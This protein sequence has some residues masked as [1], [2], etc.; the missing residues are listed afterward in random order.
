MNR[1]SS[2]GNRAVCFPGSSLSSSVDYVV[3][4]TGTYSVSIVETKSNFAGPIEVMGTRPTVDIR[5]LDANAAELPFE[6][7]TGLMHVQR[8]AVVATNIF[9]GNIVWTHP[10]AVNVLYGVSTT[11]TAG[12]DY[13]TLSGSASLGYAVFATEVKITPLDDSAL[14]G[15]ETLTL[16][17]TPDSSYDIASPEVARNCKKKP[18]WIIGSGEAT[19]YSENGNDITVSA[20][21]QSGPPAFAEAGITPAEIDIAMI[22]DSF[23]ITVLVMLEDLGFCKKGEGGPFVAGERL[24]FKSPLKP[25]INTDGGGLSSNHPGMRGLFLLLEATRQLRGEST[26]QVDGAKLAVA[27]G[28]GGMLATSHTGG[29]I[30]L[31]RD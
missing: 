22:Y 24:H 7:S 6:S 26:S 15:A 12:S 28:N 10:A 8:M 17:L 9:G 27:H 13:L 2:V 4:T 30:I 1:K 5:T 20:A 31:A 29:T 18:V 11:P 16:T 25:V 3:G 14:E 23:T 19:K 21:A